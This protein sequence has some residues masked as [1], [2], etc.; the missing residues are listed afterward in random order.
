MHFANG[1]T[2]MAVLTVFM[3]PL[4]TD[5]GWTRMQIAAVTSVGTHAR[6]AS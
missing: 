1:T 2:A 5:C 3:V 4:S 6:T